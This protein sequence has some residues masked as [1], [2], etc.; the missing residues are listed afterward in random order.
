MQ[1]FNYPTTLLYGEGSLV[2]SAKRMKGLGF[3]KSLLVTD[4]T[5]VELGIVK[6]VLDQLDL[7][8]ISAVV[9]SGTHPN[10]IEEDCI[11]GAKVYRENNCDSVIAVGGGSPMDAAKG[12]MVLGTH[13][14]PLAKYDDAKGGDSF[15][16]NNLPPLVAIP[17]TAG[18]GSEVG[19]AGVII[20]KETNAKTII[21]HPTMLPVIAVLEPSL[22]VGLPKHITAATGIDAFIH[23][24]EAYFAPGFHPMADGIA[25]EGMKLVLDNLATVYSDGN[26]LEARGKML[27]AASMG[28]TAFQKGLGMIHSIAH[29]LSSECGLHHGLANAL[30]TPA[31]VTHLES[32]NLNEEQKNRIATVL[33][34][35]KIRK[36]NKDNLANTLE[37]Y[38]TS[39]GFNFGLKN[40]GVLE[41]QIDILSEK[42]QLD[43]CHQTNMIPMDVEGFKVTIKKAM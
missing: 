22:T 18:T 41:N 23:S 4:A 20:I 6:T 43:G 42:A 8:G 32:A 26:N 33:E 21:F 37:S 35:F 25:I 1:Q 7:Q 3:K 19:R 39:L 15:I 9:F 17:T 31:C 2:E 40:H 12:I 16:T 27:L 36:M 11:Q 10:P 29:P 24:L 13:D 38:F 30:V 28:A 34:L 14:G 5:L